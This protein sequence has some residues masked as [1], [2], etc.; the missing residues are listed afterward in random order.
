MNSLYFIGFYLTNGIS[1]NV[2]SNDYLIPLISKKSTPMI[3]KE[4]IESDLFVNIK[5]EDFLDFYIKVKK[6]S[7]SLKKFIN[8]S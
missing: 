1:C 5:K 3:F 4:A 7:N 2:Y 8:I 6:I